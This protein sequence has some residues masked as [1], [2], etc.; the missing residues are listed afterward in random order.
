M[1]R[2]KFIQYSIA[3]IAAASLPF[4]SFS[5]PSSIVIE[6]ALANPKLLSFIQNKE[7]VLTVGK[8]YREYFRTE[9]NKEVLRRHLLSIPTNLEKTV[10]EDFKSGKTIIINGWVLS[11][12]EA[13]QCALYSIIHSE[14]I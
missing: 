6:E 5:K 1:E 4:T 9:D 8:V 13:R 11:L 10:E 14:T 12:T 3:G 7:E 2:R